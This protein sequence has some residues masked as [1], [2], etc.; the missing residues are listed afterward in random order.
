V[1]ARSAIASMRPSLVSLMPEGQLDALAPDDLRDL[2]AYLQSPA[3]V[4]MKATAATTA[5]LFDGSSLAFW[6]GSPEVWSVEDGEIVGRTATGLA[7]NDFLV[8]DLLVADFHL[9]LEVKLLGDQGN[10][11]IQFRSVPAEPGPAHH[12]ITGYQADVGPGWWGKLYEEN[13]RGLVSSTSGEPYVKSGDW[14]VY[15]VWCAGTRIRT[16]I[17]GHVT[18][19]LDD[20][21]GRARGQLALQVHSGGP[22][23]VRFR[24]FV[25]ELDVAP[26]PPGAGGS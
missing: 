23:E 1:I 7:H 25:L 21:K 19:D 20:P 2:V 14:N 11:G 26:F 22:T 6:S 16:A 12:E 5:H 9:R 24:N 8:S 15:D 10:S 17:N 3:Q 4:P 18:T 13:G